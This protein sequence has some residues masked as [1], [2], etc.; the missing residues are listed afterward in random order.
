MKLIIASIFVIVALVLPDVSNA[1][2]L[3]VKKAIMWAFCGKQYKKSCQLGREA[4]EV[5]GCE[6]GY[7]WSVWAVNG[8]YKGLFQMGDKER[9]DYGL[10]NG[11]MG[12][13]NNPWD[14][15]L[16][17]YNM[18]MKTKDEP[19]NNSPWHRWSCRPDGSVAY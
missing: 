4:V 12:I 7:T 9:K 18:Y 1:N 14:Q 17:G 10:S 13:G 2:I 19:R 15:A 8:Q 3:T 6:T 5:S 11:W 16:S